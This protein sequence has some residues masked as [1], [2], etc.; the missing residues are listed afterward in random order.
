MASVCN[1]YSWAIDSNVFK[2][3]ANLNYVT[4]ITY[5]LCIILSLFRLFMRHITVGTHFPGA[6]ILT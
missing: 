6:F 3:K 4:E 5:T 2:N 1:D